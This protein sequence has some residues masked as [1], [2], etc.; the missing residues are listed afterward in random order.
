MTRSFARIVTILAMVLIVLAAD[1]TLQAQDRGRGSR[2]GGGDRFGRG[3]MDAASLLRNEQVQTELKLSESQLAELKTFAEKARDQARELFSG[4][5]DLSED[6]RRAKFEEMRSKR[7]EL[8][9]EAQKQLAKVLNETQVKR[10]D[11]ITLQVRG[12]AALSDS[13]ISGKLSLSDEQQKSIKDVLESQREMQREMY[14]SMRELRDLD[15]E[16]RTAKFDELRKKG[17][18]LT[19][20]AKAAVLE[21]LSKEQLASFEAMQGKPFELDRRSMFGGGRGRDR[22]GGRREGGRRGDRDRD[23]NDPDAI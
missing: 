15:R 6:E 17:K 1:A 19:K 9:A 10:L 3:G 23:T 20:E 13:K 7:D 11:E 2:G 18:E 8:Q 5:R 21:L 14:G 16:A 4:L 12:I 22:E